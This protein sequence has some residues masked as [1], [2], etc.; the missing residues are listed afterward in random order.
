[1]EKKLLKNEKIKLRKISDYYAVIV[2]ENIL[3]ISENYGWNPIRLF[4]KKVRYTNRT[5]F[6]Y[7]KHLLRIFHQETMRTDSKEKPIYASLLSSAIPL[8]EAIARKSKDAPIFDVRFCNEQLLK[9]QHESLMK[10]V[11]AIVKPAE[12]EEFLRAVDER[13]R[14]DLYT[15]L[16]LLRTMS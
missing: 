12:N 13:L 16:L 10:K 2:V 9:P 8:M 11:R 15:T 6:G 7:H 5:G 1:M 4:A 14:D 3:Q